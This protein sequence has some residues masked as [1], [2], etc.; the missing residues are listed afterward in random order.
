MGSYD[1]DES[2]RNTPGFAQWSQKLALLRKGPTL[3]IPER[4]PGDS[5]EPDEDPDEAFIFTTRDQGNAL[6]ENL[7]PSQLV[8]FLAKNLDNPLLNGLRSAAS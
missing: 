4:D 2:E 8:P 1:L 3:E 6:I 5:L 7:K